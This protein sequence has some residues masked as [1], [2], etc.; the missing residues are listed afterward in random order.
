MGNEPITDIGLGR[1]YGLEFLYQKKFT[2][3]YYAILAYT[4]FRSEFTAF[5]PDEFLPSTWDSRHLL[6][7]TGGWKFGN[8][9]ELSGRM[10][11]AGRTPFAPVDQ[12]ATLANYPSIINDFSRFGEQRL[13]AF[14]QTD[15]RIDKK[16][17]YKNWTLNVFLEIQ[18]I[19]GQQIPDVPQFGLARDG[20]GTELAPRQLVE[21]TELENSTPL[22][23]IGIVIDF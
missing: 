22:P 15:I 2:N 19:L 14:N 17:N 11:M 1:T 18:N 12:T 20:M 4:L 8:N 13:D 21:I 10:R 23:S 6:T 7:F 3:N 5:N 16:W 9:W